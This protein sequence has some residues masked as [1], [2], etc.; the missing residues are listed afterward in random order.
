MD[1]DQIPKGNEAREAIESLKGYVYQ[2]LQSALAWID[3]EPEEFLFLEVAEDYSLVAENV[4]NAVQVKETQR[5]VTINSDDIVASIDSFVELREQNPQ[6]HVKLRHLTT[7]KIGLEKSSKHRIGNIPLLDS[8]RRLAKTGDLTPLRSILGDSKL[9]L[10]TK[11]YI[12]GLDDIEFREGFLKRIY[13]DCG[14]VE[15]IYLRPQLRS[16]LLSLVIKRGGV[17]SQVDDCLNSILVSLLHKATLHKPERFVERNMLEELLEKATYIPL[18][19]AQFEEQNHLIRKAL[20]STVPQ[21]TDLLSLRRQNPHPIKEVPLPLAIANRAVHIDSIVLSVT[22]YGL[23]W[24][25]G[26][27]GVGKTTS[28]RIAARHIG[29]DWVSINLRG[30]NSE[31]VDALLTD[32][33]EAIEE[34]KLDG[35]LVDDFECGFAPHII[36]KLF[37]LHAIC[38][39]KDVLLIFTASRNIPPES[40]YT[41]NL[42]T[43]I[44]HRLEEFS[45]QDIQQILKML[46]IEFEGW[47]KYIYF[48]SGG[49]HPQLAAAAIQ[50]MQSNGW[51]INELRTLDSLLTGNSVVDQVRADTRLRLL[52]E[53]PEGA[54]RLLERLSLRLGNFRRDF[55]LDIAQVTPTVPDAGILFDQLIGS[56]V[57]QQEQDRFALSPLLSNLAVTT[58]SE[59][60]KRK[61]NFEIANSILKGSSLD[62]IDANTAL[63]A[64]WAGKNVQAIAHL[65][66]TV[67]GTRQSDL[68]KIAPHLTMFTMMRTDAFAY[69]SD[70]AISQ[71][72]R[73]AQLLLVCHEEE[74]TEKVNEVFEIYEKESG[75]VEDPLIRLSMSLLVFSRLLMSE[76]KIG[77]FPEFWTLVKR[78]DEFFEGK[79]LPIPELEGG[80]IPSKVDGVSVVGFMFINQVNQISLLTQLTPVFEF[81]SNC[82]KGFRDRLLEPVDRLVSDIDMLVAG[83]WLREQK[84]KTLNPVIHVD[85]FLKLEDIAKPW[86]R[87]GI[88]VCCRKYRA[89]ILDECGDDKEG[90][91]KVLDEGLALYGESNSELLR[92]KARIL[93]RAKDHLGNLELSKLLIEGDAPLNT[94]E[95]VFLGR[96]AAIS[97]EEQGEYDTAKLYYLFGINAV[98]SGL[99]P[100]M[101]ATRVGLMADAA[102]ASWHGGDK[103]NC[104]REFVSVLQ[105]VVKIDPASSLR[106]AHC[107]ATCRH[108]LLWLNQDAADEER[109]LVD[110]EEPKIYPGI[111]S[112]PEPHSEIGNRY[113]I[114]IDI[115]APRRFEWVSP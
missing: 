43:S 99:E 68:E 71:M 67:L 46:G 31:Q 53:L 24:I 49:G 19:R 39:R 100:D 42:P 2:I 7:S 45:E 28:A 112:N 11:K 103:E 88:A 25:Y 85:L 65:C 75:R 1:V 114:P 87:Y 5:N 44:Q 107:H 22:Q 84:A 9:S 23:S 115:A 6:L 38:M 48:V 92:A 77:A 56:W 18:N 91:L 41:A 10:Q 37:Y 26:A 4:L 96:D 61:V 51:N 62:P 97:A 93:Y 111:V 29:G 80:V 59:D 106:A 74:N 76:L 102:L 89:I 54:R 79:E 52:Y 86:D 16:K 50:S 58:L 108:V 34:Q 105:E 32:T 27:A 12:E 81:L 63:L 33:I 30:V 21:A 83:A 60:Q 40:L 101:N 72:F 64:A 17:N 73:G 98:S 8:W 69:E 94:I 70:A 13:F 15:S 36:D 109:V 57:D 47:A 78:L 113:I 3:L 104:L 90:A 82:E 35:L 55:V 20:T 66:L 110:G 14:A 95:K